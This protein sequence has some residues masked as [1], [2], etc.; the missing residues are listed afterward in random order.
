MAQI[1][2][3]QKMMIAIHRALP[4]Q[5]LRS[6][7][8]HQYV[9]CATRAVLRPSKGVIGGDEGRDDVLHGTFDMPVLKVLELGGSAWVG[10]HQAYRA[11][12]AQGP[13]M[14]GERAPY[15]LS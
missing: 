5:P 2:H 14:E 12:L 1:I 6:V 4:R 3:S 8:A 15:L 7:F 10:H 13:T 11:G 9:R